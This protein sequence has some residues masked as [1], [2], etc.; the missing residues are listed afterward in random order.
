MAYI[1]TFYRN[2]LKFSS[3]PPIILLNIFVR[4]VS[5][6]RDLYVKSTHLA[7]KLLFFRFLSMKKIKRR[8]KRKNRN[9]QFSSNRLICLVND[10]ARYWDRFSNNV[11]ISYRV[12]LNDMIISTAHDRLHRY[13]FPTTLL[14]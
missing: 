4:Y 1:F 2:I 12:T 3:L 13:R 5:P 11:K 9:R 14:N 10:R 6:A 7:R 8:W